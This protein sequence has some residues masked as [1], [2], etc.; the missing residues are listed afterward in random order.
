[1]TRYC[2]RSRRRLDCLVHGHRDVTRAA[3]YGGVFPGQSA[4]ELHYCG[5]CGG[6]VWV[7]SPP[8]NRPATWDSTGLPTN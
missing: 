6:P 8:P 7:S 5:S 4:Q 1:M 3:A 2:E